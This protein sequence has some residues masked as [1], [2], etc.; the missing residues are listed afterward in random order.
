MVMVVE[1]QAPTTMNTCKSFVSKL[2]G[3]IMIKKLNEEI[4][5]DSNIC[6]LFPMADCLILMAGCVA[7][8]IFQRNDMETKCKKMS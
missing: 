5:L 3:N 1:W 7:Y 8:N 2:R 6:C 4:V